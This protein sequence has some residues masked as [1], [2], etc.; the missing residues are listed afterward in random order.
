LSLDEVTQYSPEMQVHYAHGSMAGTGT[1]TI[2]VTVKES[3]TSF[4]CGDR[5]GYTAPFDAESKL[6]YDTPTTA[7]AGLSRPSIDSKASANLW[8]FF[9][10]LQ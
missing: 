8:S 9:S 5:T 7:S 6:V 2:A 10:S 4:T 3:F 1:A